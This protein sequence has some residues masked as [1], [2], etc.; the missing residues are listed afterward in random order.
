MIKAILF[1]LDDT[2]LENDI[3]NFMNH[4]FAL[5]G[6]HASVFMEAQRF[7]AEL[8]ICTRAM[9]ADTDTSISN[10]DAFWGTF[11]ER[12]EVDDIAELEAYFEQF[13]RDIFPQLRQQTRQRASAARLVQRCLDQG[14][15]VVV[16]T[17]PVFPPVAIEHRLAWAGVP[18]DAY[19]F[20]LVTNY[21]NMHATKPHPAYY[22][23][24]LQKIGC[25]PEAA[26]MVGD[27][28]ENDIV[29]ASGLGLSTYWIAD[30]DEDLPDT[31]VSIIAQGSLERLEDLVVSGWLT[32]L[33]L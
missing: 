16:A 31:A 32:E 17:N 25:E 4:Y 6:R 23:E 9:M 28:W 26:L 7:I 21:S 15:Q 5:L 8:L 11:A 18:V 14:L 27:S 3:H 13:Y 20:A 1:D 12:N 19:P 30:E 10:R 2:L 22:Q 29:P 24:I 33:E